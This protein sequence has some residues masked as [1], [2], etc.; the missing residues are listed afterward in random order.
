MEE[1]QEENSHNKP[2]RQK[3]RKP[4]NIKAMKYTMR[5]GK[6]AGFCIGLP[7]ILELSE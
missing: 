2:E 6:R 7:D 1:E 5:H 4:Q 3:Y